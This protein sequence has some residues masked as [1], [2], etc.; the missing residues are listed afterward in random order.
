MPAV[1]NMSVGTHVGPHNGQSPLESYISRSVFKPQCRFPFAAA[2]N[3]GDQGLSARLDLKQSEADYMNFVATENCTEL[4]IEFWW[5]EA[6]G[7]ADMEIVVE[8]EASGMSK[9]VIPINSGSAGPTLVASTVGQRRAVTFLTLC[10]SQAHGKMSCLAF[11][12]TRAAAPPGTGPLPELRISFDITP[13]SSNAVIHAWTVICDKDRKSGFTQGGPEGTVSVPASDP[14]VV[15]V[16]AFDPARKQMWRSSSRGPASRYDPTAPIES[17]MMA[18]LS[19]HP[20]GHDGTSFASPRGA[21]D[22]TEPLA[23]SGTR[24]KC[25]DA[26]KLI[27]QT[28]GTIGCRSGSG[29]KLKAA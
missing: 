8:T 5:G 20:G 11:A 13:K 17:P 24:A 2:G 25:T 16:A 26:K 23:K 18:H 6:A 27:E 4:L 3:E 22:A 12:A 28:Y 10:Q 14:K 21:A 19:N 1:V 7:P 9:S 29:W 15:S